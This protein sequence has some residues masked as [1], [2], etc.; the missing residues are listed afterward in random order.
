MKCLLFGFKSIGAFLEQV[1]VCFLIKF[2]C[3]LSLLGY[4]FCCHKKGG[5]GELLLWFVIF[6][7]D[8]HF[9]GSIVFVLF[10]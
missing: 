9:P 7:S 5:Q 8:K 3:I 10:W 1:S 2:S 4:S 6:G